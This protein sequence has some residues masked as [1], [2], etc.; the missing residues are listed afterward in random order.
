MTK[1][2]PFCPMFSSEDIIDIEPLNPVI[3]GH[4]LVIPR[5]HVADFTEDGK[6]L[7]RC[8][9]YASK[10]AEKLGGD[11][12]LITSKGK[13]ATQTVYH[14]HIHLVPR[15]ENDGLKLPWSGQS[16]PK[17]KSG[18]IETNVPIHGAKKGKG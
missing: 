5:E 11:F 9:E 14:L 3:K 13:N 6:V 16:P 1:E 18:E 2:C 7:A 12:N 15:K 17:K 4:R 10:L 8:M